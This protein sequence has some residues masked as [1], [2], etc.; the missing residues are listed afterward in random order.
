MIDVLWVSIGAIFGANL[1]YG[2]ARLAGWLYPHPF[3]IGTLIINVTGSFILGVF[4]SWARN[5]IDIAPQWRLVVAVGFCGGYTTFSSF[6]WET[7]D[8]YR[9]GHVGLFALNFL[10][11]NVLGLLAVIAG[12]ALVPKA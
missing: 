4:F 7:I 5:H 12:I 11:N 10:A 3:P 6:A 9:E 8:L 2:I 1:R